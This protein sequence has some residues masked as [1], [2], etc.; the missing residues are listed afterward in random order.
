MKSLLHFTTLHLCIQVKKE[1]PVPNR[2]KSGH[3][4]GHLKIV[5]AQGNLAKPKDQVTSSF[6]FHKRFE[7]VI[8]NRQT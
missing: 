7:V 8:E 5:Q 6:Y 3:L 1:S 2:F 4:G